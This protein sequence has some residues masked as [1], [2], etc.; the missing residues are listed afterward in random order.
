LRV[1]RGSWRHSHHLGLLLICGL[2][3]TRAQKL[4]E[5]AL[6]IPG[7]RHA[8]IGGVALTVRSRCVPTLHNINSSERMEA[9]SRSHR[10]RLLPRRYFASTTKHNEHQS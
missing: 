7:W 4:H 8:P 1:A 10:G 2:D 6:S 5:I 9:I 3:T